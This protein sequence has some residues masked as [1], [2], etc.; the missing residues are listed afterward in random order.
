MH[1]AE[2]KPLTWM[3]SPLESTFYQI[4]QPILLVEHL[5]SYM[6]QAVALSQLPQQHLQALRGRELQA[7]QLTSLVEWF[8][9]SVKQGGDDCRVTPEESQQVLSASNAHHCQ[10][11][12]DG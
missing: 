7:I 2:L 8:Q 6:L 11:H 1:L 3:L 9:R 4:W 12:V 10:S 5:S